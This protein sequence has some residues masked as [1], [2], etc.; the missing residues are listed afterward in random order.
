MTR[1]FLSDSNNLVL[2]IG[3]I[4]RFRTQQIPPPHPSCI[5]FFLLTFNLWSLVFLSMTGQ[6]EKAGDATS[7]DL[8]SLMEMM[9][10]CWML[11]VVRFRFC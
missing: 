8:S 3:A 11:F 10:R 1:G 4:L 9:M 6:L 7:I 5:T 2:D